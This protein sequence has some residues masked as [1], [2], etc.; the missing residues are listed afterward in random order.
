MPASSRVDIEDLLSRLKEVEEL[1]RFPRV[2]GH[3]DRACTLLVSIARSAPIP[4][5]ADLS[6]R[7]TSVAS[8]AGASHQ[9]IESSL[10]Q[11]RTALEEARHR[12]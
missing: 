2:K 1:L 4:A 6:M 8:A 5:I 3:L 10:Q 9:E 7:L 11:L 12:A